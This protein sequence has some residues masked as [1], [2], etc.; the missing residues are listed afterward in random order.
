MDHKVVFDEIVSAST[1][2]LF[3]SLG[4]SVSRAQR[5]APLD[6]VAVIGF[7]GSGIRGSLG[8][9]MATALRRELAPDGSDMEDWHAEV[10]NQL[11]GR[12]KSK[13]LRYGAPIDMALP[14][15]LRGVRLE[16]AARDELVTYPFEHAAGCC[17]AWL[18]V[19]IDPDVVLA[20]T[21]DP[22]MCGIPEGEAILF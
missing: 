22:D 2:E 4:L 10:A 13:L 19:T 8:L 20:P 21:N 7:T 6:C 3:G 15:V 1:G 16:L 12:L 17:A 5:S 9:G 14:M 11:L 18:D